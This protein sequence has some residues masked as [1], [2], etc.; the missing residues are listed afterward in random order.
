MVKR[1]LS[2]FRLKRD[3]TPDDVEA[4]T[5]AKRMREDTVNLRTATR[6][7]LW[8]DRDARRR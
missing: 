1:L 7:D 6:E 3:L 2:L 5:E 8:P 4:R